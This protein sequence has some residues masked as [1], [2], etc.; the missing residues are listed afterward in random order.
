MP[1]TF[2]VERIL[3]FVEALMLVEEADQI[4]DIIVQEPAM[5]HTTAV[6]HVFIQRHFGNFAK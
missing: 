1:Q 4:L 2:G 5:I 6:I 3:V